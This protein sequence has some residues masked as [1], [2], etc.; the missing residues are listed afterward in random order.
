MDLF[1][2]LSLYTDLIMAQDELIRA[3]NELLLAY[4]IGRCKEK[5]FENIQKCTDRVNKLK[6][7]LVE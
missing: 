1:K 5:I 3:K 6:G 2:K 7:D 4:R